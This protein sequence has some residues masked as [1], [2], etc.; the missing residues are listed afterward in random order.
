[1]LTD[2][3]EVIARTS[4]I[5]IAD[6][7]MWP[8]RLRH[9]L[10]FGYELADVTLS[11]DQ[12][13]GVLCDDDQPAPALVVADVDLVGGGA[14]ELCRRLTE[15]GLDVPVL[16]ATYSHGRQEVLDAVV[17]GASG[18]LVRANDIEAT[19]MAIA[20][21]II[22]EPVINPPLAGLM[23][24]HFRVFHDRPDAADYGLDPKQRRIVQLVARNHGLAELSDMV[25]M[26]V[27]DVEEAMRVIFMKLRDSREVL[28]LEGPKHESRTA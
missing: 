8:E 12:T 27:A 25:G 2:S 23:L 28:M 26:S 17:A 5:L 9:D 10:R 24:S 21:A 4:S 13:M 6:A 16:V 11:V 3:V 1:M 14:L 7:S 15:T 19:R 22:G 18:Y 20:R